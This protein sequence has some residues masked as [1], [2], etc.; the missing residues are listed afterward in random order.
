MALLFAARPRV[1]A[2]CILA[3][4]PLFV[5]AL[6]FLGPYLFD[7][8]YYYSGVAID[9][10][11][12]TLPGA[13][14]IDPNAGVTA[15][16]LGVH[17]AEEIL[18][19]RLP[20]WNHY[21]G[22]GT[23][24]LGEMQSAA[25]FP[26]TLLLLLPHGQVIF[27]AL[28]QFLGGLGT[29]LFLRRFGLGVTAALAGG[30]L[31]EVNGVFAWLQNAVF[32]P[33]AFLPWMF[34][35]IE[36]LR[37]N[38]VANKSFS[39]R[40]SGLCFGALAAALAIYAG[41][42][43]VVYF[44]A[45]LL[46]AWTLFRTV[47]L[48]RAQAVIFFADLVA[49]SVLALALSAPAL[50]AF[51]AFLREAFVGSHTGNGFYGALPHLSILLQYILPYVYGT[52]FA[53]PHP[54][55]ANVWS[56]TG[57]YI[58]FMPVVAAF[59][60]LMDRDRRALKIF[61][62]AWIVIALGASHGLPLIYQAFMMLPLAKLA[63]C[64]RYLNASW[65]FGFI[66]LT[67]L[68]VDRLQSETVTIRRYIPRALGIGGIT[69]LAAAVPAWPVIADFFKNGAHARSYTIGAAVIA[70][71]MMYATLSLTRTTKLASGVVAILVAEAIVW[72]F[73]PVIS[74]ARKG[75]VDRDAIAFLQANVGQQ[76][77]LASL[78]D[79][80]RGVTPNFGAAFRIPTLNYDD[81]PIPHR[82]LDYVRKNLD[83]YA[84][85]IFLPW[86]PGLPPEQE[87][88]RKQFFRERLS[89][90]ARAGVKYVLAGP[91]FAGLTPV[92]T[93]R[94]FSVYELPDTRAY[95]SAAGCEIRAATHDVIQASCEAPSTLTRLEVHM[96]GWT[97]RVNG[98]GTNIGLT[99]DTFQ[100][101]SLPA[102]ESRIVFRYE[103]RG[104]AAAKFAA[105][106]ALLI[107]LAVLIRAAFARRANDGGIPLRS[108]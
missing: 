84:D 8:I 4:L 13:P 73:I 53:D 92:Q 7:A 10:R 55:V 28:L 15:F 80:P 107:I 58:G 65:I 74:Y 47:G 108:A 103:P 11:G 98:T 29:F 6:S 99:E 57:G 33:V 71:A 86:W 105:L 76:R 90:Y 75:D 101:V 22:L 18:S 50:V 24:L 89:A 51:V 59:A 37:E 17:A 96:D 26:P 63:A 79:R 35:A 95:V 43:E 88:A 49:M 62:A 16:A 97:A 68:F 106:A 1:L 23:P 36:V 3:A 48:T 45:L 81:L 39:Q 21:A 67:A 66:F 87:R 12:R 64:Y 72:F 102:G 85:V 32:N 2:G 56:N 69:L 42:P 9:V 5:I 25:L 46:A 100:T 20:L 93:F 44:Y 30:I 70:L 31:F 41:F 83:Q 27:H 38:A 19:G 52:I 104:F 40:L 82:T 78:D 14:T 94:A 91:N 60:A 77:V 61:L 54:A 34:F